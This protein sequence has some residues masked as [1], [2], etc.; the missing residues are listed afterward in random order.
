MQAHDEEGSLQKT[1]AQVPVLVQDPLVVVVVL[2]KMQGSDASARYSRNA[3]H[4]RV[5]SDATVARLK[6]LAN[7]LDIINDHARWKQHGV[8]LKE[9]REKAQ[10]RMDIHTLEK[11]FRLKI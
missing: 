9:K 5:C 7:H 1:Q 6:D 2:L 3:N 11:R 10:G 8:D 4:G